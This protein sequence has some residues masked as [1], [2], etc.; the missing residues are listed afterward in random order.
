MGICF[1][2]AWL[3]VQLMQVAVCKTKK[4][5]NGVADEPLFIL[6][7]FNKPALFLL[8]QRGFLATAMTN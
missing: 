2:Q 6:K 5:S 8:F 4:S 1:S 3:Y 7:T